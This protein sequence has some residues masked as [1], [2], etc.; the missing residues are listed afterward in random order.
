MNRQKITLIY[1][2]FALAACVC[3][4]LLLNS[5]SGESA[6]TNEPYPD[7]P[8]E[9]KSMQGTWVDVNTNDAIECTAIIQ[10]YTIRVRY[11]PGEEQPLQKHNASIDRIDE[12]RDLLILNGGIGAWPY[13][14]ESQDN[15]QH[16]ELEFF[17]TDGWHKMTLSR[18]D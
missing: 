4:V 2:A 16:L 14:L 18:A 13:A 12:Q 5:C 10:G 15:G 11:A 17:G 6:S 7:M 3:V 9:L 8:T 1:R